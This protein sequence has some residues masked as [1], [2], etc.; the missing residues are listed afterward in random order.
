MDVPESTVDVRSRGQ[1][2]TI[3]SSP[4]AAGTFTEKVT[5][6]PDQCTGFPNPK[7]PCQCGRV[8]LRTRSNECNFATTTGS[9]LVRPS[10]TGF[11]PG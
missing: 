10:A 5:I 2:L 9:I 3:E 7:C 6:E 4:D 1:L 8:I 11:H